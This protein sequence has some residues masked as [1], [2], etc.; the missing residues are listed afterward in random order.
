MTPP[1]P[2]DAVPALLR[3]RPAGA[4]CDPSSTTGACGTTDHRGTASA[5]SSPSRYI[6]ASS[7]WNAASNKIQ[8]VL[9]QKPEQLFVPRSPEGTPNLAFDTLGSVHKLAG[10]RPSCIDRQ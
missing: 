6:D 3:A 10:Q 8:A 7:S 1:A 5:P 9:T 4:C 2:V